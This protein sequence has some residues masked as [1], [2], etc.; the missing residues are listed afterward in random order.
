MS[1]TLLPK[2]L[3]SRMT[4]AADGVGT[5]THNFTLKASSQRGDQQG[6]RNDFNAQADTRYAE[7]VATDNTLCWTKMHGYLEGRLAGKTATRLV[8]SKLTH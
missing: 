2:G 1:T 7:I 8:V 3:T 4:V 5:T 6:R